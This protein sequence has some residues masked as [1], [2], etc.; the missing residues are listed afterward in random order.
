ME[1]FE[2]TKNLIQLKIVKSKT[3]KIHVFLDI[4]TDN[5][6]N[7]SSL[8]IVLHYI[9]ISDSSSG[10]YESMLIKFSSFYKRIQLKTSILF[11]KKLSNSTT[12]RTKSIL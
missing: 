8:D 4:S 10:Q 5:I 6:N 7:I 12:F 2:N 9:H 1:S 11:F 3:S